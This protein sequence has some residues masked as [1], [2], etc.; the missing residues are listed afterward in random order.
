MPIRLSDFY[1][2]IQN[3][4][5]HSDFLSVAVLTACGSES[6]IFGNARITCPTGY[7]RVVHNTD[8]GTRDVFCVAQ[9]EMKNVLGVAAS[10]ASGSP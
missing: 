8:L 7:I 5:K 6:F 4:T 3:I 1:E 2:K 10:E 9:F